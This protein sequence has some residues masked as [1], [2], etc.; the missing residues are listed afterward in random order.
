MTTD[1][2]VRYPSLAKMQC[3]SPGVIGKHSRTVRRAEGQLKE[4]RS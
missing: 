2:A 1:P 4:R 3:V